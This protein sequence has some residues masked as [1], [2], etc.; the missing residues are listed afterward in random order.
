MSSAIITVLL[1]LGSALS[2]TSDVTEQAARTEAA[3]ISKQTLECGSGTKVVAYRFV[4]E[5][6]MQIRYASRTFTIPQSGTIEV[7]A[8]KKTRVYSSLRGDFSIGNAVADDFGIVTIDAVR[9]VA[10]DAIRTEIRTAT[11][12]HNQPAF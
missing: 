6:G 1:T 10:V 7:L 5:P 4:G 12:S 9:N 11:L 3:A 2:I 8:S